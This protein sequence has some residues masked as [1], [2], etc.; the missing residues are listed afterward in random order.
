MGGEV[1]GERRGERVR[2]GGGGEERREE[3][4]WKREG[5]ERR[6]KSCVWEGNRRK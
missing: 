6:K 2:G 3:R 1:E 4:K 5:E